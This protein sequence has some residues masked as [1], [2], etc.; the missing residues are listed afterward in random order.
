M[1]ENVPGAAKAGAMRQDVLLCGS[2]FVGLKVQRHRVFE[3]SF[4][5]MLTP[6]CDHRG[7]GPIAGV[8]GHPHGERGAWPGMLPS[9]LETWR[10]AMGMPWA[11]AKGLAQA[12]PPAY[13]KFIGRRLLRELKQSTR[14]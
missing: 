6:G 2:M 10:E 3:T 8:Y 13:T 4:G 7:Q 1:I 5:V 12:I 9:T 14:A 11:T